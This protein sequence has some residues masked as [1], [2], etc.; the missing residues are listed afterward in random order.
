MNKNIKMLATIVPLIVVPLINER[1][2]IKKHPDVQKLG[3]VSNS[4]YTRVKDSSKNAASNAYE[5]TK[6]TAQNIG[7][8]VSHTLDERSYNK[9]MKSYKKSLDKEESLEKKFEKDKAA[10]KEKREQ[11]NDNNNRSIVPKI[12]QSSQEK[13]SEEIEDGMSVSEEFIVS[14]EETPDINVDKL[15]EPDNQE[16]VYGEMYMFEDEEEENAE[17]EIAIHNT[18]QT[19]ESSEK[20]TNIRELNE[21]KILQHTEVEDTQNE[22]TLPLREQ[23]KNTLDPRSAARD[24]HVAVKKKEKQELRNDNSLFNKHRRLNFEHANKRKRVIG[25]GNQY[26]KDQSIKDYEALMFNK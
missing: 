7:E 26:T 12:F 1:K 3:A 17:D 16:P 8:K 25:D 23:H 19:N 22:E 10:H 6:S 21:E 14:S 2:N 24:K 9:E 18:P 5:T 20:M 11:S 4:V 13:S 15:T